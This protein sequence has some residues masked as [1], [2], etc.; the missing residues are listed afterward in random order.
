MPLFQ[1]Q[2]NQFLELLRSLKDADPDD[3]S[4]CIVMRAM[5]KSLMDKGLTD[6]EASRV[7]GS[8]EVEVSDDFVK[9][10]ELFHEAVESYSTAISKMKVFCDKVSPTLFLH[11]LS[12]KSSL[13]WE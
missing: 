11:T 4:N 5:H 3:T 10:E 2:R 6:D 12:K 8:M 7:V 13:K 9:D 1:G